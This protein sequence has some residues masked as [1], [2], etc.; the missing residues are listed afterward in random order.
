MDTKSPAQ[1]PLD[2]S[3]PAPEPALSPLEAAQQRE[4]SLERLFLLLQ[5][6]GNA[7]AFAVFEDVAV[8]DQ[9]IAQVRQGL[10]QRSVEEVVL[11]QR[12]PNLLR[13]IGD[14]R[15]AHS[16]TL[17]LHSLP[18]RPSDTQ[19]LSLTLEIQRD[20][21]ARHPVQLIFLLT[22][23][24]YAALLKSAPN[25]TSRLNGVFH[26]PGSL[27]AAR[28][29]AA[30]SPSV[31]TPDW[32]PERGQAERRR[33]YLTLSSEETLASRMAY[34][35]RRIRDLGKL[36]HP[37]WREI[38]DAW[39]DLAGLYEQSMPRRWRDAESAYE[40]AAA[41]Y[42]RCGQTLAA[43][44]ALYQAG[45]AAGSDYRHDDA[46]ARL[47]RARQ[48]FDLLDDSPQRTPLAAAGKGNVLRQQAW[49]HERRGEYAEAFQR[50]QESL[51]ILE[52]VG[53]S[54]GVAICQ[55]NLG[56]LHVTRG[57]IAQAK[58]L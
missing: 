44:E 9:I 29:K 26:F 3:L 18:A 10:A 19:E 47:H 17:L 52:A 28:P 25:F 54:R 33:P 8:R 15:P 2:L 11:R 7:W 53:D 35:Q 20:A 56:D 1:D 39:Y 46:M 27:D 21:L 4:A 32:Q 49:M 36:A 41:A 51:E 5:V 34:L 6:V 13:L 55:R 40:E 12:E 30:P 42:R 57:E 31:A 45:T 38:G 14:L 50:Y 23:D 22:R 48:E 43:A 16:L 58:L 24:E 37:D